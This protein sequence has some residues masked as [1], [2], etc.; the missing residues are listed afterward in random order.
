M[1]YKERKNYFKQI[2][3]LLPIYRK[4]EK[5]FINDLKYT[6]DEYIANNPNCSTDDIIKRFETPSDV[7]YNYIS[8]IDEK[9]LYKVISSRRILKRF[10]AFVIALLL[11]AFSLWCGVLYKAHIDSKDSIITQEYTVIS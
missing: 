6:V 1:N 2:K 8:S 4:Q 3:F 11:V 9:D 7:V 5:K 10:I